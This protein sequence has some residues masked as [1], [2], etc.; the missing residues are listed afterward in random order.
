MFTD[1]SFISVS[2]RDGVGGILC[3]VRPNVGCA[4]RCLSRTVM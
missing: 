2:R 4:T 1:S 3:V